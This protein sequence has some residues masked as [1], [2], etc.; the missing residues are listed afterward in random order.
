MSVD[1]LEAPLQSIISDLERS[2][3]SR[4]GGGG[5]E[6]RRRRRGKTSERREKRVASSE[7]R[8]RREEKSKS[9]DC[10]PMLERLGA[11]LDAERGELMARISEGHEG[12]G[13]RLG[14]LEE[15]TREELKGVQ[16]RMKETLAEERRA[17]QVTAL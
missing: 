4:G 5:G 11:K 3:R 2:D 8:E 16:E 12:L 13:R 17:C 6:A 9:C 10:G 14:G 7:R 1:R 15:R